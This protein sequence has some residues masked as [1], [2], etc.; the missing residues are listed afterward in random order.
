MR[1]ERKRSVAHRAQ[2]TAPLLYSTTDLAPVSWTPR[3]RARVCEEVLNDEADILVQKLC[4]KLDTP[5]SRNRDG[6]IIA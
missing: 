5:I 3:K 1:G 2:A 6:M 4:E